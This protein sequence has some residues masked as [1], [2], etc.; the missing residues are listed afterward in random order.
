MRPFGFHRCE[1]FLDLVQ[2]VSLNQLAVIRRDACES[3]FL[4]WGLW[5]GRWP[6][7]W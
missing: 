2:P 5:D 7:T 6:R 4:V 1:D 3:R